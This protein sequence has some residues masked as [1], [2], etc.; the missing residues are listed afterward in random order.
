MRLSAENSLG[1]ADS[2]RHATGIVSTFERFRSLSVALDC[3]FCQIE[4]ANVCERGKAS[5]S[6]ANGGKRA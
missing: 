2:K 6:V 3:Q 1:S 4:R 5:A